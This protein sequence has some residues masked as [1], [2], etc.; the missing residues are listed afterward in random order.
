LHLAKAGNSADADRRIAEALA[1]AP[2]DVEVV[3]TAAAVEALRGRTDIALQHLHEAVAAGYS[4]SEIAADD[5]FAALRKNETFR[6]LTTNQ[7]G[8]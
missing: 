7:G 6:K 1:I 8:K 2:R 4:R 5:D 3:F